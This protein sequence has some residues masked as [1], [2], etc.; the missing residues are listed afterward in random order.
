MDCA[1]RHP[2]APLG[3]KTVVLELVYYK[4]VAPTELATAAQRS[5]AAALRHWRDAQTRRNRG[6]RCLR[7]LGDFNAFPP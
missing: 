5:A 4:Q 1:G 2:G 3:L 6:V 7:L